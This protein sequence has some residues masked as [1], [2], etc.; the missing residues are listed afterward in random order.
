[1][2][3]IAQEKIAG[4]LSTEPQC[5][6]VL[7]DKLGMPMGSIKVQICL[8]RKMGLPIMTSWGRGYYVEN[9]HAA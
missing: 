8:M 3:T 2:L 6:V 5:L 7:S 9:I 1:M 4:A